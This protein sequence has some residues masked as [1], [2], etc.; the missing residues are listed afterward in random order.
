MN[1]VLFLVLFSYSFA[2]TLLLVRFCIKLFHSAYRKFG[3]SFKNK[4][5]Q[6]MQ[7]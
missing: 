3:F 1:Y 7:H 2:L 6:V 5:D 4:T